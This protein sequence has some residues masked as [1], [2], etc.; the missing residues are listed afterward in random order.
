M[1]IYEYICEDCGKRINF[2][3][4]NRDTFF[5]QCNRCNS[6]N[7]RRIMSR[8]AAIR[9]E[10]SRMES[11]ADP[12]KWGYLNENDPKSM[13][14]FVKKMGKEMGDELGEN[15]DDL[16]AEAESEIENSESKKKNQDDDLV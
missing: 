11:L 4:L 15:Y 1:P 14:N 5:P 9:S 6:K 2:L 12:G 16:V 7:L 13:L 10:E 8:F 3:V